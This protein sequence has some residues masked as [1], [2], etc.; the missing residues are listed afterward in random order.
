MP[1]MGG[2]ATISGYS[3]PRPKL[4]GIDMKKKE[5][6]KVKILRHL[7]IGRKIT[8]WT[9]IHY[10]KCT[11]L[12][13]VIYQLRKERYIIDD[14]MFKTKSGKWVKKYWMEK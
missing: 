9:A 14:K 1:E 12:S 8:T 6:Q 4:E 3:Q 2:N 11:R 5:S 10:F 7:K 13:A